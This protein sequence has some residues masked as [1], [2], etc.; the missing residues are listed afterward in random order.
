MSDVVL[1]PNADIGPNDYIPTPV[2][3]HYSNVAEN[4]HDGDASYLSPSA[5]G[6]REVF[7]LDTAALMAD[8][9][10]TSVKLRTAYDPGANPASWKAGF[11][12]GGVDYFGPTHNDLTGPYDTT[13]DSWALNP[14][15]GLAWTAADLVAARVV[16]AQVGF[17]VGLPRPRL[18]QFIAIAATVTP[19]PRPSADG[20]GAAVGA[21]VAA[22]RPS[23]SGAAIVGGSVA[24]APMTGA[25]S[26]SGRRPFGSPAD[27]GKPR[28]TGSPVRPSASVGPNVPT[29]TPGIVIRPGG[30]LSAPTMPS[31]APSTPSRPAGDPS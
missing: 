18:T 2:V 4:P 29:A 23:A 25:A 3:A 17:T 19:P 14:A 5:S 16:H 20:A 13:E 31:A 1:L 26:A 8:A 28:A 27:P 30:T 12:I 24:S 6:Q 11:I 10:I 9:L 7:S 15:T 22:V 21:S